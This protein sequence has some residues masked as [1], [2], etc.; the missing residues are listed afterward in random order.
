MNAFVENILERPTWQKAAIWVGSLGLVV[1]LVWQFLIADQWEEE[2]KLKTAIEEV[3]G[4]IIEEQRIARE[5]PRFRQEVKD[6]EIKL[7]FALQ[8]LPDESEIPD[9]LTS[10]SSLAR[11][12][13]LTVNLFKP[14]AENFKDFYAEVPVSIAVEG[15]FHQIATF[16]DE[17]GHLPRIVNINQISI[18]D[19]KV[20][21]SQVNV[22]SECVATTF[23]YLKDSERVQTA[24]AGDQKKRRKR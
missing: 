7:K 4:K 9:L 21:E 23:R 17:V 22:K 15:T 3:N 6:L 16:F 12:A 13:G 11:D 24:E 20:G 1:Y 19:P 14:T 2:D 10:I 18:K 5:L 8:E